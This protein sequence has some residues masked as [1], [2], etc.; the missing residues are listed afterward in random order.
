MQ[1]VVKVTQDTCQITH[2]SSVTSLPSSCTSTIKARQ[3]YFSRERLA[4]SCRSTQGHHSCSKA[5]ILIVWQEK[6]AA[7]ARHYTWANPWELSHSRCL[8]QVHCRLS[9]VWKCHKF[10]TTINGT[11]KKLCKAGPQAWMRGTP[12]YAAVYEQREVLTWGRLQ[13]FCKSRTSH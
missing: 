7:T 13:H 1:E 6:I 5:I 12:Y 2:L 9:W 8:S 3:D 4:T 10:S 11:V